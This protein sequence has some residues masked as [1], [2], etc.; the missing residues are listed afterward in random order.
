M[1]GPPPPLTP[2]SPPCYLWPL[3]SASPNRI[4]LTG[5]LLNRVG[6]LAIGRQGAHRNAGIYI[7]LSALRISRCHIPRAAFPKV[8]YPG[9]GYSGPSGLSYSYI[10]LKKLRVLCAFLRA[11][12]VNLN[13]QVQ[14]H[15]IES[16]ELFGS[17]PPVI[18]AVR[19]V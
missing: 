18:Q 19:G 4:N 11:L 10:L 6:L 5:T 13:P 2:P 1:T 9:L 7:R 17:F 12:C 15:P 3:S 14:R 16:I 8:T